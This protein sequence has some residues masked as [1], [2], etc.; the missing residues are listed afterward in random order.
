MKQYLKIVSIG[1][2]VLATALKLVAQPDP[3]VS[4]SVVPGTTFVNQTAEVRVI[5]SNNGDV[6][7]PAN[8]FEVD[9]QWSAAYATLNPDIAVND[10]INGFR[11]TEVTTSKIV[12]QNNEQMGEVLGDNYTRTIAFSVRAIAV[13]ASP[14][15]VFNVNL[16]ILPPVLTENE[17]EDNDR[18]TYNLTI[19]AALPVTLTDFK[20]TKEGD[21]AVL[22]WKTSMEE[23]SSYFEVQHSLKGKEWQKVGSIKAEGIPSTY[24]F[25][26]ANPANGANL[27]RLKMVDRDGTFSYSPMRSLQFEVD[28]TATF[29]PNPVADFLKIS[30]NTD[31]NNVNSVKLFNMSGNPVYSSGAVPDK[32]IS[33]RN[34]PDGV[35]IVQMSLN[36]GMSR[37]AKIIIAK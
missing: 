1:I 19:E 32:E 17:D 11:V 29:A 2:L 7:I 14:G 12:L 4:V 34:L 20:A 35:Y 37:S 18:A 33:V 30:T 23:N 27:Y 28:L 24:N 22:D 31:W 25:S 3:A 13:T 16:N 21:I 5:A 26:H 15:L 9:I 6:I 8:G 10:I 36:N